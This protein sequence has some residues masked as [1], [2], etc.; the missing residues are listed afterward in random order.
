VD[1]PNEFCQKDVELLK[2]FAAAAESY[3]DAVK[4][5]QNSEGTQSILKAY[6]LTELARSQCVAARE[7]VERHRLQHGCRNVA[8]VPPRSQIC[9]KDVELREE[10]ATATEAYIDAARG[11]RAAGNDT[12]FSTWREIAEV[13][14][15]DCSRAREA[16]EDHLAE[17]GC[18]RVGSLWRRVG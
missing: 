9:E 16:L 12:Q 17:H 3:L 6:R 1:G 18:R 11:L 5:F 14:R 4:T 15:K 2:S 10:Y 8:R 7:A 13:A